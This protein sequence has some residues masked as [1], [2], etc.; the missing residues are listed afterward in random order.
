MA[1]APKKQL[2][3]AI[4]ATAIQMKASGASRSDIVKAFGKEGI[5]VWRRLGEEWAPLVMA[6]IESRRKKAFVQGVP[7]ESGD[8]VPAGATLYQIDEWLAV[9][10]QGA[11]EA[12]A[13]QD[14]DKH[15]SYMRMVISLLEARR[16]AE[17]EKVEDP[18]DSPD[19]VAAAARVRERWHKL[20]ESLVR[21]ANSPL[22]ATLASMS[23]R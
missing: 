3:P 10:K 19:F 9:A 17:P 1:G 8:D 14:P 21:V 20:A 7:I 13:L 6:E 12:A 22:A 2:A 23:K 11:N 4:Q 18:N 15:L 16:K 5:T